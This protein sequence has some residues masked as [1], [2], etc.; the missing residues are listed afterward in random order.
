MTP[1]DVARIA[2]IAMALE[3]LPNKQG[4]T[5]RLADK[6]E[7]LKL[8]YFIIGAINSGNA[9]RELMWRPEGTPSYDLLVK[10]VTENHLNRAGLRINGGTLMMLWP[11]LITIRDYKPIDIMNL[12]TCLKDHL[13]E[14]DSNDVLYFQNAN[15][16]GQSLWEGHHKHLKP[17]QL[18]YDTLY[19]YV[20]SHEGHYFHDEI[21]NGYPTVEEF[22]IEMNQQEEYSQEMERLW[23]TKKFD[24]LPE[25]QVAD[26]MAVTVFLAMYFDDYKIV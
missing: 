3:P 25:G 4:L 13:F 7:S 24:N 12:K 21:L 15:N 1:Q 11:I 9:I 8:E 26:L 5:T 20:K 22:Y 14:T 16:W 18:D 17:M 23:R 10:C 6:E 19:D 2:Q